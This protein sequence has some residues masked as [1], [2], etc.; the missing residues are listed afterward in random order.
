M[1]LSIKETL[2]KGRGMLKL[3]F[4]LSMSGLITVV[5]SYIIRIFIANIGGVAEVGFYNAGYVIMGTYVGMVFT[6]MGTDYYPRLAA[7]SHDNIQTNKM[8]NQQSELT[9]LVIAPVL[10]VFMIFI[11]WVII[12]LYTKEFETISN[13]LLWMALGML[14]KAGSW[15][16]GYVLPAKGE[17]KI[18]FHSEL[19]ANTYLLLLNLAGYYY[20]GLEGLGISFLIGYIL[21]YLQIYFITNLK[22]NFRF[23]PYFYK[24]M[25]IQM[26]LATVAFILSRNLE[27][28]SLYVSGSCVLLISVIIS[29][30]HLNK[31]LNLFNFN[32]KHGNK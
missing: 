12:I 11:K 17:G 4:L 30:Y 19:I 31:K 21:V 25:L 24:I 10:V 26:A 9:I 16:V 5:A 2:D 1:P 14:F 27:G 15:A 18:F 23:S 28:I 3:G 6:A 8:I 13:M 20:Y 22:F 7:V 32:K 29:F